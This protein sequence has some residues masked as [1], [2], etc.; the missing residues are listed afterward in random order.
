MRH[1]RGRPLTGVEQQEPLLELRARGGH[2]RQL[3]PQGLENGEKLFTCPGRSQLDLQLHVFAFPTARRQLHLVE[4][5]LRQ[6]S[7]C[8]NEVSDEPKLVH[9]EQDDKRLE[10]DQSEHSLAQIA[11]RPI[12][13]LRGE[14]QVDFQL[15]P[16][17]KPVH[18]K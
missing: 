5:H 14:L 8:P 7:I 2:E 16:F 18:G 11:F 12:P 9:L 6:D 17:M 10:A 1:R 4:A 3:P 15:L 13:R